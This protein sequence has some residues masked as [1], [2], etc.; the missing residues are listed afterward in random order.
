MIGSPFPPASPVGRVRRA[1]PV[2]APD[3]AGLSSASSTKASSVWKERFV[4]LSKQTEELW[5]EFASC[6]F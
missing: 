5:L 3:S 4:L 6:M 2:S 1:G